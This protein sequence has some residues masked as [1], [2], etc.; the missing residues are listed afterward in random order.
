HQRAVAHDA[1]VVHQDVDLAELAYRGL[2]DA[3][4][5]LEVAHRVVVR[6][7]L[8]AERLDVL[9]RLR[10]RVVLRPLS[11]EAHADVVDPDARA[12]PGQPRARRPAGGRGRS[13]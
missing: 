2:D 4:G 8:G 11:V 7:R 5:A 12:L 1:G 13:R 6:D 10:G 9:A 3:T